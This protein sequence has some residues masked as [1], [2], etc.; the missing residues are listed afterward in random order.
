[1][2]DFVCIHSWSFVFLF[3]KIFDFKFGFSVG[4]LGD[5]HRTTPT[6]R[7]PTVSPYRYRPDGCS[8][9]AAVRH[10]VN[11][12]VCSRFV[13]SFVRTRMWFFFIKM[14]FYLHFQSQFTT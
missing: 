4:Y 1:M 11:E 12:V 5:R 9:V 6:L 8:F 10:L 7:Y 13:S 2:G 14:L 3:Q